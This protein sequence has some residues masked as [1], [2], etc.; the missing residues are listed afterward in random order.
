ME[1]EKIADFSTVYIILGSSD[2]IVKNK[3]GKVSGKIP[4]IPRMGMQLQ[5]PVE[6]SNLKWF[7]RGP[8]ENYV[9][10]TDFSRCRSL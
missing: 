4:E 7:G 6:F 10:P 1:D 9:R 2:V 5:L 3:F 8:H